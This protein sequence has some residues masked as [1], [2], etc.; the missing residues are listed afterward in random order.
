MWSA[1]RFWGFC[2]KKE[3]HKKES[4]ANDNSIGEAYCFVAIERNTKLVLNFALGRRSQATTDIF[5]EG[6]RAAT[7]E[8]RFQISTDG[9][10][11]HFVGH[12]HHAWRPL[13]FCPNSSKCT[14]RAPKASALTARRKSR[15]RSESQ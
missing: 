3:G 11:P 15:I 9:F 12:Y 10:R 4:E 6:L 5:I 1:M 8:Q 13:R 14:R 7:S 2:K